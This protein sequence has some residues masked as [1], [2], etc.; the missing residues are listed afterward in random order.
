VGVGGKKKAERVGAQRELKAHVRDDRLFLRFYPPE[1]ESIIAHPF[2][3]CYREPAVVV[4]GQA[5][6]EGGGGEG[7]GGEGRG[8]VD[9]FYIGIQIDPQAVIAQQQQISSRSA[10]AATEGV[11]TKAEPPKIDLGQDGQRLINLVYENMPEEKRHPS[12]RVNLVHLHAY[13]LPDWVFTS[14]I[15]PVHTYHSSSSSSSSKKRKRTTSED[16]GTD[17]S[18]THKRH[19]PDEEHVSPSSPPS[20]TLSTDSSTL[21]PEQFIQAMPAPLYVPFPL[22]PPVLPPMRMGTYEDRRKV[23]QS[24]SAFV[25]R[26]RPALVRKPAILHLQSRP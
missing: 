17:D 14:S 9:H 5:T 23:S 1:V 15:R 24:G 25:V 10:A 6:A 20:P 11:E 13:Q 12:M 3:R 26:T 22:P 7:R 18:T 8:V 2:A 16:K 21:S 4:E 19:F